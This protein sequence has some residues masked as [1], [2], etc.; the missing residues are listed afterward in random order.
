MCDMTHSYVRHDS[1]PHTAAAPA[2]VE[3]EE[4]EGDEDAPDSDDVDFI[5]LVEYVVKKLK[6][7]N[8]EVCRRL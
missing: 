1:F 8:N 2:V 5:D 3:E 7:P 6:N 4:E